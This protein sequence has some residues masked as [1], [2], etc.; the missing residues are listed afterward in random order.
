MQWPWRL[1]RVIQVLMVSTIMS[2]LLISVF[3]LFLAPMPHLMMA[4]A[5]TTFIFLF[6]IIMTVV[7][8]PAD[9]TLSFK[10]A[11]SEE[12]TCSCQTKAYS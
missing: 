4:L 5:S 10:V 3:L 1:G 12:L 9:K 8:Q 2:I 6:A 7:E 11:S